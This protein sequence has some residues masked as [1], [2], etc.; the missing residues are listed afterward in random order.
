PFSSRDYWTGVLMDS[1]RTI[2]LAPDS[3]TYQQEMMRFIARIH[4]THANLWSSLGVRPPVGTCQLPVVV[5]F[6]EGVPLITGYNSATAGPASG[7]KIGDVITQ[8]DGTAIA[9][10]LTQ[11][12]PLYAD[13]NQAARLRD[14][15]QYMTQGACGPA[16]VA[17]L[18]DG[19][20]MNLT[21]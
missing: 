6:V 9:D 2:A 16:N 20:T 21:A 19:A 12:E 7:L 4:D 1:I 11:W 5:R 3:L 10:L 18:R 17:V 14:I 13:S 8:L 15:G